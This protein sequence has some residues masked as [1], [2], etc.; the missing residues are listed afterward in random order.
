MNITK[1]QLLQAAAGIVTPEHAEALWGALERDTASRPR[2]DGEHVAYYF[3]ALIVIGAMGWFMGLGWERFGGGGLMA[4]ALGYAA[5]FLLAAR[6]LLQ[7]PALQVPGGLLVTIAVGMTPLAAYGFERLTGLWPEDDP[8][9]YAEFH[10]WINGSWVGMEVATIIAGL[11]ALRFVRFPFLTAPIAFALWYL[12]MDATSLLI[13]E[14]SSWHQ[15][16]WISLW[17]G[18][19]VLLVAFLVDRRTKADY[20]F[21]LYLFGMFAFWGGMSS[22]DSDSEV[23]KA[24]YCAINVGLI[25]VSVL[26]QRRIFVICGALGIMGYLGY[27]AHR[28]FE[29]SLLFPFALSLI[30]IAVIAFG[31]WYHR[32]RPAIEQALRALV[33]ARI[34][35]ALPSERRPPVG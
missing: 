22:M 26:L 13:G 20:A 2:F 4:L 17:F 16:Q 29:D 19:V 25:V 23:G 6:T 21:W 33:P 35:G 7:T 8:G 27:L 14:T 9:A 24:A 31:V 10:P 34:R 5:L 3:G 28:V 11:I 30:G 15:R 12:S 18:L 32:C 1:P